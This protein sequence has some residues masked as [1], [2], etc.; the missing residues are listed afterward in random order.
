MALLLRWW[1]FSGEQTPRCGRVRLFVNALILGA[2]LL[3]TGLAAVT[4]PAES[5]LGT[6]TQLGLPPCLWSGIFGTDRCPSC[7][8][9]TG[10]AHLVRGNWREAVS[11]NRLAPPVFAVVASVSLIAAYSL[12][13]DRFPWIRLLPLL[14][15]AAAAYLIYW[16]VA[17]ARLVG[18]G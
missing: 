12:V 5:G 13:R 6:H 14:A 17:M 8:L 9:T 10:F 7:G 1:H 11:A 18:A 2:C 3:V 4:V 16:G 15:A